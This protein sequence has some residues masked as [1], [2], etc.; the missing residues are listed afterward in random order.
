MYVKN[1][2]IVESARAKPGKK[3]S[4]QVMKDVVVKGQVI[5]PG[6]SVLTGHVAE[7]QKQDQNH[8]EARLRIVF[9][10]I[11]LRGR[12]VAFTG[13]L[14]KAWIESQAMEDIPECISTPLAPCPVSIGPSENPSP[15]DDLSFSRF[16]KDETG[17]GIVIVSQRNVYLGWLTRFKVKVISPFRQQ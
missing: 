3:V 1:W 11:Q 16:I 7:V 15:G 12:N 14:E 2:T 13:V 4:A 17:D 6:K 5:I 8:P 10:S 9:D